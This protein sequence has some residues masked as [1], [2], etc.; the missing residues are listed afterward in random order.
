MNL[1]EKLSQ[2]IRQ[3]YDQSPP[4]KY[5]MEDSLAEFII[6]H[7]ETAGIDLREL[8]DNHKPDAPHCYC[9]AC[10]IP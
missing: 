1:A 5:P 6:E 3:R 2:V 7:S 8:P 9:D 10:F 4:D